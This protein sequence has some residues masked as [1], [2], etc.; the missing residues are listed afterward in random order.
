[1]QNDAK[2]STNQ[3]TTQWFTEHF[4]PQVHAAKQARRDAGEDVPARYV[5]ILDGVAT[6][7]MSGQE[8]ESWIT[9]VQAEDPNL[10]LLWLP[11]NMTDDL[12]PLDVNFNR[13]FKA[14]YR[15][16]LARLKMRQNAAEPAIQQQNG[17]T[18]R[19]DSAAQ[20]LKEVVIKL[21]SAHT[22]QYPKSKL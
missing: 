11:P 10:I 16:E 15:P 3:T 7:C 19:G 6:H 2:W 12:Q 22:N 5:V 14:K 18:P 17:R 9:K 8:S 4:I 1:M 20:K 13:P 21:S